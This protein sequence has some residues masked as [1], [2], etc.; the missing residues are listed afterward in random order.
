MIPEGSEYRPLKFSYDKN[1]VYEDLPASSDDPSQ[2]FFDLGGH[3]DE[4]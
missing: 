3:D 4:T 2:G 1:A